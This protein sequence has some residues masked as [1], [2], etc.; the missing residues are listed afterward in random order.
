MAMIE[1][2]DDDLVTAKLIKAAEGIEV[3]TPFGAI[4]YRAVD[5]QST[6]GGYVGKTTVQ[7]GKGTMIDFKY[8]YGKDYLPSDEETKKPRFSN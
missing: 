5:H 2:Q 4:T 6:F 8:D 1:V 3:D 7:N